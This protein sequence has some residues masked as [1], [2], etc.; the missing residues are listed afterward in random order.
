MKQFEYVIT[1]PLGIHARPA[2]MLARTAKSLN[3]EV[4]IAKDGA[5]PAI[6][7]R[8]MA[9]M[10]MGIKGG[11]TVTVTVDGGDEDAN[12]ETMKKFFGENL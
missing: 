4:S 10:G 2:G 6:A 9:I 5:E 3:S 12:L 7:S 8:L 11:D 1:D